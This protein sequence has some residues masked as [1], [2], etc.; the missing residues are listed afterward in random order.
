M[1]RK[2]GERSIVPGK[3]VIGLMVVRGVGLF[4]TVSGLAGITLILG[5]LNLVMQDLTFTPIFESELYAF[6]L[7]LLMCIIGGAMDYIA[8]LGLKSSDYYIE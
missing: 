3:K 8:H 4:L 6:L 5:P 1:E 2:K 7:C